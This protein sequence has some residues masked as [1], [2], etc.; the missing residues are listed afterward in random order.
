MSYG[1]IPC[2]LGCHTTDC[3]WNSCG[4]C[5]DNCVCERRLL[6]PDEKEEDES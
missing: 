3:P 4:I 2:R 5:V 1:D 6:E